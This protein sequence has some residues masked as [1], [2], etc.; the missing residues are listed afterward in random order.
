MLLDR[1]MVSL[2]KS[3]SIPLRPWHAAEHLTAASNVSLSTP[4]Q[5]SAQSC[6]TIYCVFKN[7]LWPYSPNHNL[8]SHSIRVQSLN[9]AD[10]LTQLQTCLDQVSLPLRS[11][12]KSHPANTYHHS[13]RPNSM[14]QSPISQP[15]MTTPP[16]S[17]LPASPTPYHSLKRS[18]R[19]NPQQLPPPPELLQT[20]LGGQRL[21][22][23]P[24]RSSHQAS[25]SPTHL[26]RS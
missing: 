12:L 17:H 2:P 11:K 16:P 21:Q 24:S 13:L 9:M 15:I 6:N 18:P 20:H 22:R 25:R 14:P 1:K 7:A 19:T 4:T 5:C 23:S 26:I 10:I 8:E 3:S